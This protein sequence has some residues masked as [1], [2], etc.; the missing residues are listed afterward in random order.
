MARPHQIIRALIRHRLGREDKVLRA[1]QALQPAS[2]ESLVSLA[3]ADTPAHL[4][5]L[6][7]RSLLAHLGKLEQDGR[8]WA[9]EGLWSLRGA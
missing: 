5:R 7:A 9:R 3:Y 6:A 8:A 4:H 2:V 1:L